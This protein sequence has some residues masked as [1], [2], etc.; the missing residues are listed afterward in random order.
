MRLQLKPEHGGIL[1][2]VE[3]VLP[4]AEREQ[5]EHMLLAAAILEEVNKKTAFF[6]E[7]EELPTV[8]IAGWLSR[9]AGTNTVIGCQPSDELLAEWRR[10]EQETGRPWELRVKTVQGQRMSFLRKSHNR[11][12]STER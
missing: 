9:K 7:D 4:P 1:V 10:L 11:K 5:G 12:P 3:D 8:A 2:S 6:V